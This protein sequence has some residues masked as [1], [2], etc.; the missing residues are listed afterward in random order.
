MLSVLGLANAEAVV[1]ALV[2]IV[3]AWSITN[4]NAFVGVEREAF[5]T[6][7]EDRD[8]ADGKL[9]IRI[10]HTAW[11][12]FAGGVFVVPN[13]I[14]GTVLRNASHVLP[15]PPLIGQAVHLHARLDIGA[16]V[17]VVALETPACLPLRVPLGVFRAQRFVTW[18][19]D[20]FLV[21]LV[22]CLGSFAPLLLTFA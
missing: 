5:A 17:V 1:V 12:A 22:P 20:A 7:A 6:R 2:P 21:L 18:N 3:R 14:F 8:A 9:T 10:W 19:V 13:H 16:L 4:N 15:G 11:D